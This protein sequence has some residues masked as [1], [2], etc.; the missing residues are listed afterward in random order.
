MIIRK[1]NGFF[2]SKNN[3]VEAAHDHLMYKYF[4]ISNCFNISSC[5]LQDC[6]EKACISDSNLKVK[7]NNIHRLY[8]LQSWHCTKLFFFFSFWNF[9]VNRTGKVGQQLGTPQKHTMAYL[10]YYTKC[11]AWIKLIGKQFIHISLFINNLHLKMHYKKKSNIY[12]CSLDLLWTE[13]VFDCFKES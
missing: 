11:T 1:E 13:M 9:N 10:Q 5:L 7:I 8:W 3:M 4:W 6:E 12:Q 2:T